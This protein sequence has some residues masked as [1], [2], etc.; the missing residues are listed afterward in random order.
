MGVN[1]GSS[2]MSEGTAEMGR[3][4]TIP[5]TSTT[6]VPHSSWV[7]SVHPIPSNIPSNTCRTVP[8]CRSH[9]PPKCNACGVLNIHSQ[10]CSARYHSMSSNNPEART[11]WPSIVP[12]FTS[13]GHKGQVAQRY[14]GGVLKGDRVFIISS[15]V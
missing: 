15:M 2:W 4:L 1:G 9:T 10:P 3:L 6:R 8:I 13:Y 14:Q 7:S 5:V 12:L 11:G